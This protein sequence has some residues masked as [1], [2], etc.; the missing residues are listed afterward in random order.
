MRERVFLVLCGVNSYNKS[1]ALTLQV[2]RLCTHTYLTHAC[3]GLA[4]HVYN[5]ACSSHHQWPFSTNP[6]MLLL[7]I[8]RRDIERQSP[9]NAKTSKSR[10]VTFPLFADTERE[11]VERKKKEREESYTSY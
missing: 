8:R 10:A 1:I 9:Y 7:S 5:H 11:R 6:P 2:L 4:I 3:R